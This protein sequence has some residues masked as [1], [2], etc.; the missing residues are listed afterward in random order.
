MPSIIELP[1]TL[2][3]L[4]YWERELFHRFFEVQRSTGKLIL[5]ENM[6]PWADKTFG[7][8]TDV[9]EQKIVK[10]LDKHIYEAALFNELRAKRPMQA[11]EK[12]DFEKII[13]QSEHDARR[14][15]WKD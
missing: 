8:H 6:K 3:T 9:E 1:E 11:K 15:L 4:S 7:R 10:V 12:G 14:H 2:A 13:K 5:P